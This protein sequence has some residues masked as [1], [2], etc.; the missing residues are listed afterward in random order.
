[1]GEGTISQK[2]F[3]RLLFQC[4]TDKSPQKMEKRREM[5]GSSGERKAR[6]EVA[7]GN[8]SSTTSKTPKEVAS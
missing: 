2:P 6:K 8:L 3:H 5:A 4:V 7:C 1:M